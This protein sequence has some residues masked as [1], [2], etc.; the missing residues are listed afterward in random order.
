MTVMRQS[1]TGR[2]SPLVAMAVTGLLLLGGMGGCQPTDRSAFSLEADRET[3]VERRRRIIFNNDGDDLWRTTVPTTKERFLSVRT[4]HVADTMVDSVFYFSRRPISPLYTGAVT[5][6]PLAS[7]LRELGQQGTD[8]LKLVIEA[9][10]K[11]GIE[12][13]WSMRMNDIHD[14]AKDEAEIAQWKKDHRH[15]LMGRPED[16][17]TY[18]PTDPRHIW[19]F[20]DYAH[21]EVRDL[22]VET[23]KEVLEDYDVDG[24][25][26]DFLRHPAFFQET[27][28]FQPA[29][30]PHLE[31]MTD[32]VGRIR[33]E[34]LAA[35][36]RKRKPILMS[37]RILP[38][39][40][41]NRHFGFDIQRWVSQ[42]YV[43][44]IVVGGG[45]DPFTMPAKDMIDRGHEWGVPVYVCLSS[46]GFFHS[47]AGGR[48]FRS[49]TDASQWNQSQPDAS[50]EI[51]LQSW[52]AA[53]ANA[54]HAGADGIMTFNLFPKYAGSRATK[55][56]RRVW[57]EI[58]DPEKLAYQDKLY[59][60]E[61]LESMNVGFMMGS[62]PAEGRLPIEV[63][64]G[65][66]VQ[67]VLPVADDLAG[68]ED[69][70]ESLRLRLRLTGL[71]ADDAVAVGINEERLNLMRR[72]PDWMIGEVPARAMRQ[73][74]NLLRIELAAAASSSLTL[75]AIELEVKYRR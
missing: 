4:D 71:G 63:K 70:V 39:L 53:A 72:E 74:P 58:G 9:C 64:P 45:Y 18:P 55:M 14:N 40:D 6:E 59:V 52:R 25:D 29:T 46:S 13:F 5:S 61:N 62:V 60:V 66:A 56:A 32:L 27:R 34:V 28:L 1:Q 15:L 50:D 8:D 20:V 12:V 51:A 37:V 17:K 3:A 35:S 48:F 21:P 65:A 73:G 16:K 54:W 47:I 75:S 2:L 24:V 22:M 67:R 42:G 19:T 49:S 7:R 11:Q 10:R 36:R 30:Q 33:K 68:A 44:L 38:T 69:R 43:D 23:F 57:K 26:L 41:Q 31:M